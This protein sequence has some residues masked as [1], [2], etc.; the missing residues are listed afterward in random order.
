MTQAYKYSILYFLAFSL[1]LLLSGTMLFYE[2]LG[3]TQ[4]SIYTYYTG[5]HY[6]ASKTHTGILKLI[7]PHIF[8]FGLFSMVI[9]HF[10]VF[11]QQRYKK[12]TK[13][14][15]YF[16]FLSA[17][18]ELGSPFLIINYGEF[19]TFM[20]IISFVLFELLILYTGYLLLLS[21]VND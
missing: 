19:F 4:E 5:G 3:F 9:L 15:V 12:Q 6:M 8:A 7:L 14:L 1:L 20:K 13:F 18:L 21:I 11:T 17:V 10:L 16:T 2:K